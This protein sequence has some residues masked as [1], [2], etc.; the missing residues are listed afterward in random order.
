MISKK[1]PDVF[2]KT[3]GAFFQTLCTG[4][5]SKQSMQYTY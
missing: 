3:S 4:T 1:A 5:I 2:Q